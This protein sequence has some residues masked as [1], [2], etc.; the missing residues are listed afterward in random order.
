MKAVGLRH[1]RSGPSLWLRE[2]RHKT[3]VAVRTGG[4]APSSV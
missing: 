3:K 4:H 1:K 2:Y